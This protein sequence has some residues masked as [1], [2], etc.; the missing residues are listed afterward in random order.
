MKDQ[1]VGLNHPHDGSGPRGDVDGNRTANNLGSSSEHT[2]RAQKQKQT[3]KH[4]AHCKGL[5][6][7]SDELYQSARSASIAGR[8]EA[9][10][11]GIQAAAKPTSVSTRGTT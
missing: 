3:G 1:L 11:A 4:A 5:R 9:R 2:G 6:L 7:R 8:R 10:R